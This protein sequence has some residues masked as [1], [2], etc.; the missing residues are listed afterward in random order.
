MQSQDFLRFIEQLSF[1]S[2]VEL[3]SKLL[4]DELKKLNTMIKNTDYSDT[5]SRME[6]VT[7]KAKYLELETYKNVLSFRLSLLQTNSNN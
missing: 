2:D 4:Q 6:K 3:K 5:I 1:V 7:K